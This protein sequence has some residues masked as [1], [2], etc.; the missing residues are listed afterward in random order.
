MF[1]HILVP[2]DLTDRTAGTID[3]LQ[4]LLGDRS[5]R[6]TLLHVIQRIPETDLDEFR[7][8]YSGLEERSSAKLAS[9]ALR[10]AENIDVAQEIVYGHP[11][12][13]IVEFAEANGVDLIAVAS[14]VV[15]RTQHGSAWGTISYTIG[16]LAACPVMLV[17]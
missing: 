2:T 12:S 4:G 11:A 8:F 9:L 14:H 3:T 10:F 16:M 13:A 6:V 1:H 7:D 17:K 5:I 15:D